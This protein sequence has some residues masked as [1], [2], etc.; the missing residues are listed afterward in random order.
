M[1]IDKENIKSAINRQK[2]F[3]NLKMNRSSET[4]EKQCSGTIVI[5]NCMS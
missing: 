3:R 1:Q 5:E 4:L 2:K